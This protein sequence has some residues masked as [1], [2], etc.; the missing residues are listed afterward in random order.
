MSHSRCIRASAAA[1]VFAASLAIGH[2]VDH[3]AA[4]HRIEPQ[5]SPA[6]RLSSIAIDYPEEES[7][8]PPEITPPTFLWRDS[9]KTAATWGVDVSF[10]D[11]SPPLRLACKGERM[12]L[13][14]IDPQCVAETNRPP[15]LTPEQASS[16]TW[17]PDQKTWEGIKTRSKTAPAS[18]TITG[19]E[20]TGAGRPVSRGSVTIRTS[21]D[22]VGAMVFY[23]DVPLM[24]TET[25]NGS[26]RPLA[27]YAVRL[28][29]WR[30]RDIGETNS[31]VVLEDLPM[32]ANCHSFSSDG[33][34]LGMDLDGVQ[35][36]KGLY[37]L[38][39]V[40]A[41]LSIRREDVI[42]WST[43]EGRLPGGIRV[44]FMSQVSP[45][46]QFVVTTIDPSASA[47]N[48]QPPASPAS[49]PSSI[50]YVANFKDYR[51][52]Q[53]FYPTRGILGWYSRAT[54][55]LQPLHG[56]DDPGLVQMGGVWSPDGSY[57]VF[58]RAA[59]RDPYPPGAPAAKF[60]NDPHELQIRFDLYRVPFNGGRGGTPEAI[61]GA[62]EDGMSNSFPKVSPDGRWIVF[63]KSRNGMLMRP[64]SLLYIVPASGGRARRMRCNTRL[65][66]SWHSFS[67]N[68]RWLV[69]SSK[70]R[71]PYTQMYLTHID[72]EGNDSP[73]ILI[74]K[75]TA[76][77]RAVNIPEF[78]NTSPNGLRTIG[79][80][81]LDYYRLADR[82]AYLR[83]SGQ[84]EASVAEWKKALAVNPDDAFSQSSLGNLLLMTGHPQEA[85]GYLQAARNSKIEETVTRLRLRLE[86]HPEDA[87]AQAGIGDA[88]YARGKPVEALSHW[89]EAIRLGWNEVE[90]LRLAAWVLATSPDGSIRSGGEALELAERAGRLSQGEDVSVLDSLAAALAEV[91]RFDDASK[92]ARRALDLA[93]RTNRA[94]R[95]DAIRGRV[96]LYDAR[97]PYREMR[98]PSLPLP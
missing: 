96:A 22:P 69:F 52:L 13:G 54:D 63:V 51:F 89:R 38:S 43:A 36:N 50:Y 60:A 47:K 66:N 45:D 19:F 61:A 34:T 94:A 9:S 84:Y 2:F 21:T 83:R 82:A 33:K 55:I 88:L 42:Q 77:N 14:E 72:S 20:G 91:G 15:R 68:S 59:A 37:A 70:S 71:S 18:V 81:V 93:L 56:A 12:R 24:P 27:P 98:T 4:P 95:A 31:R 7:I 75:T 76:A 3:A 40:S 80:P 48:A 26:I 32:C 73:A 16:R 67:P 58:A 97:R 30:L 41:A 28:I 25:E 23:R 49:V 8:F 85:A 92:A 39:P 78:V 62:S 6:G 90:T 65:M 17:T 79:G 53:V 86:R 1:A 74:E 87:A 29:R 64:D 10:G 57:L 11:G 5:N 46:G 44:G 35:N